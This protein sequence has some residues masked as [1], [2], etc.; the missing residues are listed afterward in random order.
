MQ[1]TI[2]LLQDVHK[3]VGQI[4]EGIGVEHSEAKEQV[5]NRLANGR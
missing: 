4:K 5:L 2:E 3:S 1:N